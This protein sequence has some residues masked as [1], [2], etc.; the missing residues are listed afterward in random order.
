MIE[1]KRP[2]TFP[3][4]DFLEYFP[5]FAPPRNTAAFILACGKR[6]QMYHSR[7]DSVWLNGEKKLY[8]L[9]LLTAHILYLTNKLNADTPDGG[10]GQEAE[11]PV[12]PMTSASVGGVSVSF[13][14]PQSS[15]DSAFKWWLNKTQYGQEYLA[16]IETRAPFIAFVG[17]HNS[18]LPLR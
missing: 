2:W 6:A 12:G 1:A 17:A 13:N 14:A 10:A 16:L 7:Y 3:Y 5:Q 11:A 15:G 9:C 8:A 18:T 4:E